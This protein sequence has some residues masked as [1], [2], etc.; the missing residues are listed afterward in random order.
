MKPYD[1]KN[2][3]SV[4]WMS[5][6]RIILAVICSVVLSLQRKNRPLID[7]IFPSIITLLIAA[8]LLSIVCLLI[9]SL[10]KNIRRFAIVQISLDIILISALVY[11]TGGVNSTF[12]HLYF[13]SLLAASILLHGIPSILIITSFATSSLA[14]VNLLG[15]YGYS[16]VELFTG[17]EVYVALPVSSVVA[18]LIAQGVAFYLVALL[19]GLLAA[20]STAE[21]ILNEEILQSMGEGLLV[22]SANNT[23]TFINNEAIRILALHNEYG[24]PLSYA[25]DIKGRTISSVFEKKRFADILRVLENKQAALVELDLSTDEEYLTPIEIKTSVINN[26]NGTYRGII[27]IIADL[28]IHRQM[29]EFLKRAERLQGISEA[30]AGI[31]H[32]IRNPLASIRGSVQELNSTMSLPENSTGRALMNII[33]KESDRLDGIITDFLR[34]ARMRPAKLEKCDLK[35]V[36]E[37]V[38]TLLAKRATN[39]N[40]SIRVNAPDGLFVQGDDEQLTQ[41]FLNIGLNALDYSPDNGVISIEA[42]IAEKTIEPSRPAT[43][44]SDLLSAYKSNDTQNKVV[45]TVS[46]EGPGIPEH[47]MPDIFTPFFSAKEGGTGIGLS[48]VE[49]IIEAHKGAIRVDNISDKGARFAITLNI[50]DNG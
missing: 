16:A 40:I 26:P 3:A 15:N 25:S 12:V 32:E 50:Y 34:Y 11:L 14:V 24:L 30:A 13:A 38:S 22:I 23:I 33:I 45:V 10:I 7:E 27:A 49:R 1:E 47:L 46:D 18:Y 43:D 19:G 37:N 48:I 31:A 20:R 44:S 42:A 29:E 21:R 5:V 36:L 17:G 8:F 41:V 39:K 9:Q 4:Q 35:A 28:T 2:K 6:F